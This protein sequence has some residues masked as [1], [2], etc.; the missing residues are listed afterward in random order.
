VVIVISQPAAAPQPIGPMIEITPELIK[1]HDWRNAPPPNAVREMAANTG[2]LHSKVVDQD[3]NYGWNPR[4]ALRCEAI[5][6]WWQQQSG[7]QTWWHGRNPFPSRPV[8]GSSDPFNRAWALRT[9]R[10]GDHEMPPA[11]APAGRDGHLRARSLNIFNTL[12][13]IGRGGLSISGSATE[14]GYGQNAVADQAGGIRLTRFP[15]Q[16]SRA[17]FYFPPK[18]LEGRNF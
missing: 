15:L 4:S 12:G 6:P 18:Y 13:R 17:D 10:G 7:P 5:C 1:R 3:A 11:H 9:G 8:F 16:S 2:D 14:T